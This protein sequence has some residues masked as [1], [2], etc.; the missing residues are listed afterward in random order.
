MYIY[1]YI[2]KRIKNEEIVSLILGVL[3]AWICRAK[4]TQSDDRLVR[5]T[6]VTI[7]FYL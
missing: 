5:K 1:I 3:Y 6:R 7:T 2:Y 4:Y